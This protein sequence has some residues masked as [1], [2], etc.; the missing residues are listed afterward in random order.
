MGKIENCQKHNLIRGLTRQTKLSA[1]AK[2]SW[3]CLMEVNT[4]KTEGRQ[5]HKAAEEA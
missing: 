5:K 3:A 1:E 4:L 2:H